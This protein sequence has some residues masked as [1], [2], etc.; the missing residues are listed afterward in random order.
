MVVGLPEKVIGA[1][2]GVFPP[3]TLA[4]VLK[5]SSTRGAPQAAGVPGE[6]GRPHDK[7]VVYAE[8]AAGAKWLFLRVQPVVAH[9]WFLKQTEV[10]ASSG[11][12]LISCPGAGGGSGDKRT[13]GLWWR[14]VV[15]QRSTRTAWG[16]FDL[17]ESSST[18][19][20]VASPPILG[21][22]RSGTLH[23]QIELPDLLRS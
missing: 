16:V 8:A 7:R 20:D 22:G 21:S 5:M 14:S 23:R 13:Q 2:D 12:E 6:A 15:M 11:S 3:E 10:L 17:W 18:M 4:M 1:V 19:G 9:L